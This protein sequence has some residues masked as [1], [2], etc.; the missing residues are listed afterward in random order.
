MDIDSSTIFNNV[1]AMQAAGGSMKL[2][3]NSIYNNSTGI[4]CTSASSTVVSQGNNRHGSTAGFTAS[5]GCPALGSI[6]LE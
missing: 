5:G 1:G 4:N 3:N 2:S 6:N